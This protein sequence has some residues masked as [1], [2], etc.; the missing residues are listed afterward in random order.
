M[1]SFTT[2]AS[3]GCYYPHVRHDHKG[4]HSG[5]VITPAC[6]WDRDEDVSLGHYLFHILLLTRP[7]LVGQELR[8]NQGSGTVCQT[9]AHEWDTNS[10]A[11][12][13]LRG[14]KRTGVGMGGIVERH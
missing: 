12:F 6:L 3:P 4:S 10:L 5:G 7:W 9:S 13:P 1:V 8:D 2:Q 11:F 14:R